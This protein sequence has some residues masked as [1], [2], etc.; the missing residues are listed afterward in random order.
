MKAIYMNGYG[1]VESLEVRELDDPLP[2]NDQALVQVHACSVNPV[3]W[4]IRKGDIKPPPGKSPPTIPGGDFAGR[5]TSVGAGFSQFQEG[6]RVWGLIDPAKGGA[7]AEYLVAK[8]DNI[9]LAPSNLNSVNAASIPLVGLTAYQALVNKGQ[10]EP[11]QQ[12]LVNGCSGGV[13]I[14]AVQIAKAL[15]CE[16]TGVCSTANVEQVT[17]LGCDH[18]IDYT[19]DEVLSAGANYDLIFDAVGNKDYGL[20]SNCLK[21]RGV[22]VTT[23]LSFSAVLGNPIFNLFRKRKGH[24]VL[25][26]ANRNDLDALKAL[27]EEGKLKPVVERTFSLDQVREAHTLSERGKV[28]G[29]LVLEVAVA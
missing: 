10:A 25:V 4:K 22:Y 17:Q 15:G 24:A 1:G 8:E 14:A 5:L 20:A 18:V 2:E 29:K 12:V 13:G 6:D 21:P 19:K 23:T 27:V 7:Y 11:G 28:V 16:V 26:K 9:G 3:D